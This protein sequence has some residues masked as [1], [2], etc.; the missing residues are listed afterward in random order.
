MSESALVRAVRD[1]IR[2]HSD[3]ADH[4]VRVEL[5]EFAPPVTGNLYVMV[6]SAGEEAG[7]RHN[8]NQGASDK[9]YHV[10]VTVC[11][12]ATHRPRDRQR[13]M[14]VG[15]TKSFETYKVAIENQIDFRYEVNDAA[16]AYILA[17]TGSSEGFIEPLK[18]ASVSP[19]R[20]APAS[21]FLAAEGET[22]AAVLRPIHFR[23]ARRIVTR[24]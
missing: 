16:D 17:E 4:Q 3:F 11:L 15:L 13:E 23:G 9:L 18:F 20:R 12:R 14:F 2:A 6:L 21:L 22:V 10:D 19:F 8:P 7:P 24:S 1:R 5:D